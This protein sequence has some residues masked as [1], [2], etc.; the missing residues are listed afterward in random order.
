MGK[1]QDLTG[2][3]FGKLTVIKQAPKLRDRTAWW[4]K[5]DC[6]NENFIHVTSNDLKTGNTKSCGCAKK[7]ARIIDMTG[8]KMWE[9]GVPDSKI[10]VLK[11]VGQNNDGDVLWECECKCGNKNHFVVNGKY[12][13]NG[14]K[15][16]CGCDKLNNYDLTNDYGIGYTKNTNQPFYFDLEDYDLISKYIWQEETGGYIVTYINNKR[17][18]IHNLVTNSEVKTQDHRNGNRKDN[19]KS[20]LRYATV[21]EN[22]R[23]RVTP[24]NN[25]T[26]C[27]GVCLDKSKRYRAY[28]TVN[29]KWMS[30]GTYDDFEKAKEVR[31]RAEIK[32]FGEFIRD[33]NKN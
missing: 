1:F 30:L 21:L 3:K 10:I 11:T 7:D 24:K 31:K 19:R 23:N 15:L 5:C 22:S 26:G 32:Y 27:K 16:S 14:F 29:H 28:I 6:G 4:C 9:H 33:E 12:I 8:W 18:F 20:N 13:R 17:L 2:Q 25:K